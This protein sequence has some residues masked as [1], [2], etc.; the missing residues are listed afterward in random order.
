MAAIRGSWARLNGELNASL[1]STWLGQA[2]DEQPTLRVAGGLQIG[3]E[4]AVECSER[5]ARL[6]DGPA[7]LGR[8]RMLK[9]RG[10]EAPRHSGDCYLALPPACDRRDLFAHV[11]VRIAREMEAIRERQRRSVEFNL[12]QAPESL[13]DLAWGD[14]RAIARDKNDRRLAIGR[15]PELLAFGMPFPEPARLGAREEPALPPREPGEAIGVE[16]ER[17]VVLEADRERAGRVFR[18]RSTRQEHHVAD[19]EC[20]IPLPFE[21]L[22]RPRRGDLSEVAATEQ[23]PDESELVLERTGYRL[24]PRAELRH[25]RAGDDPLGVSDQAMEIARG[26][27]A[28]RDRQVRA[29]RLGFAAGRDSAG[30]DVAG[31]AAETALADQLSGGFGGRSVEAVGPV[32]RVGL[33]SHA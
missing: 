24:H 17:L 25:G 3:S 12:G 26:H 32:R 1:E 6:A 30:Q 7:Q 18:P 20:P 22:A 33:A 5:D 10:R 14:D 28:V 13:A 29:K 15:D 2:H 9:K 8:K 31:N 21:Y 11:D 19:D 4:V 16:K 27:A 23:A